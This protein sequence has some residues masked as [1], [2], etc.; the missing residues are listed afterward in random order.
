MTQCVV[1]VL[2][3]VKVDEQNGGGN[4]LASCSSLHL[5]DA[6]VNQ[7]SVGKASERIVKGSMSQTLFGVLSACDVTHVCHDSTNVGI[8][9]EICKCSL[10]PKV[11]SI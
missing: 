10:E 2:E 7:A 1:D 6:I 4:A 11:V 9:G 8:G 5:F 3:V